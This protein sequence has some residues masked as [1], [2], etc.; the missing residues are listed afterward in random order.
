M[1]RPIK[2]GRTFF[3]ETG[4]TAAAAAGSA[5]NTA[6]TAGRLGLFDAAAR[7][8]FFLWV[9][10]G[11]VDA[12][13]SQGTVER[14]RRGTVEARVR[15]PFGSGGLEHTLLY[16]GVDGAGSLEGGLRHDHL[17]FFGWLV[18]CFVALC[19]V[20]LVSWNW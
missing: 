19:V 2:V 6:E 9:F 1:S 7:A 18:A 5:R 14:S 4:T 10:G 3:C 13:G 15:A 16:Q 11:I 17:V 20:S 12:D 8:L